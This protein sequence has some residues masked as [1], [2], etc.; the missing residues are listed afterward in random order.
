M[1]EKMAKKEPEQYQRFWD[2]FGEVLKEGPAEDF[3]ERSFD[4][5]G[6][7]ST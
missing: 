4:P 7:S 6:P 2:Q 3:T 1:L 5:L